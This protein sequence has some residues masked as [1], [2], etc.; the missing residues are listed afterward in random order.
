L[1]CEVLAGTKGGYDVPDVLR[2][3]GDNG[4]APLEQVV[5]LETQRIQRKPGITMFARMSA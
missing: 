2:M 5:A 1:S 4:V 3:S